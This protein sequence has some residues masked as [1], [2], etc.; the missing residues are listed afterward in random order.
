MN[1]IEKAKETL[2]NAGYFVNNLWHVDDVDCKF[3]DL[4]LEEKQDLLSHVM[5][6]EWIMKQ[7]WESMS[8]IGDEFGY[9][10]IND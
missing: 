6:D 1:E 10:F 2:R 7:I 8:E 3:K 4:S 5:T 9:K